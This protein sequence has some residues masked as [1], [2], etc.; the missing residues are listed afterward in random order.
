LMSIGPNLGPAYDS[1]RCYDV[2]R[3]ALRMVAVRPSSVQRWS[4]YFTRPKNTL[5]VQMWS[6]RTRVP[7][8]GACQM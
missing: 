8:W 2:R 6:R 3:G 4:G 7:E 5:R 1:F